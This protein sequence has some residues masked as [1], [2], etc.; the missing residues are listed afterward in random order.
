MK[1]LP[2]LN[3]DAMKFQRTA[4]CLIFS[5]FA[6]LGLS[7]H[8]A[9]DTDRNHPIVFVADSGI[10]TKIKTKLATQHL[11]SLKHIKVDTDE[12][13]VVWLSGFASTQSQ[14]DMAGAVARDTDGV[15]SVQNNIV[16]KNDE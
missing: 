11:S 16:V 14:V 4:A 3:R 10:T 7:A 8:A 15:R 9:D 12:K 2:Y 1:F 6:G 13:G 5:S